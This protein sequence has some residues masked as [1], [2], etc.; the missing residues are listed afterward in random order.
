M[1]F[2]QIFSTFILL[3]II[4]NAMAQESQ[5]K[6]EDSS[7]DHKKWNIISTRPLQPI[8]R[9]GTIGV[10]RQIYKII[11]LKAEFRHGKEISNQR[12][13]RSNG[14]K[15]GPTIYLKSLKS[16]EFTVQGFFLNPYFSQ[17]FYDEELNE[18][19]S[20]GYA[21]PLEAY[22]GI[23]TFNRF[24]SK[25]NGKKKELGMNIGYRRILNYNFTAS[26]ALGLGNQS[27]SY[28]RS[29]Y[30]QTEGG[31]LTGVR[32]ASGTELVLNAEFTMGFTF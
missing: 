28:Y 32:I 22:L 17:E 1:N 23:V 2:K 9:F 15:I 19:K 27:H 18:R 16:D 13:Y 26:F 30:N 3:L 8:K 21:S 29:T 10:E 12:Y 7:I 6:L 25:E 31:K 24:R 20:I 4:S 11:A 14:F 5:D